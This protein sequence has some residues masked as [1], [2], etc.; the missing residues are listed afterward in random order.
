MTVTIIPERWERV[1]KA[2]LR[3]GK[4][5]AP[6]GGIDV[7]VMQAVAFVAGEPDTDHPACVSPVLTAFCI[8]WNDALDDEGRQRLKPIIPRLVRTAGDPAADE[9]RAWMAADWLVRTFTPTWLRLAKLDDHASALEALPEMTA[10]ELADAALPIIRAAGN[11]AGNAAWNA[12]RDAAGGAAWDAAWDAAWNAAGSAAGGAAWDAAWN[13]ARGAAWD[14]A[15]DA[16]A[17]TVTTLQDSA[18]DLLD[19]MIE[20]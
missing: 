2:T 13:A 4:G 10:D 8:S 14:A 6:N 5:P 1:Q 12:A 3:S 16:L 19:R 11:A 20:A 15:R 18:F 9:R 7:C 17:P